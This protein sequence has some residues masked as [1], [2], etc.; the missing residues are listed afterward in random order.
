[1]SCFGGVKRKHLEVNTSS[2]E[3]QVLLSFSY[4]E[5]SNGGPPSILCTIIS[6]F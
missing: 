6:L 1:M 3:A 4:D 5:Q 2:L